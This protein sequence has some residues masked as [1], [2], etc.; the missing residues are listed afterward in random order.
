MGDYNDILY[1][2]DKAGN[3]PH[4]NWLLNGFRDAV[5]ECNL[6]D[7]HLDGYH[8]MWCR[9]LGTDHAVE[10]RLDRALATETGCSFSL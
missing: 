3:V 6:I 8:F 5:H 7:L 4:P 2:S 1:A 9:G 10:E